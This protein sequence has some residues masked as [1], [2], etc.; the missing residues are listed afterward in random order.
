[1]P[2][3]VIGDCGNMRLLRQRS[4]YFVRD[5]KDDT[6]Q[7]IN[8]IE[9]AK[10]LS[11]GVELIDDHEAPHKIENFIN[12]WDTSKGLFKIVGNK[13]Q[14]DFRFGIISE[15][16][17]CKLREID[18]IFE[19]FDLFNEFMFKDGSLYYAYAVRIDCTYDGY[20]VPNVSDIRINS[21]RLRDDENDR[22]HYSFCIPSHFA[23]YLMS[24]RGLKDRQAALNVFSSGVVDSVV[25]QHLEG[26]SNGI[27]KF[28][29]W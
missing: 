25:G 6:I 8:G 22:E 23:D 21:A 20:S 16:Y 9:R 18:Y 17:Q 19:A 12:A 2:Y 4:L 13:V 29:K 27:V 7:C 26:W 5:S 24:I 10:L 28:Y 11:N 15:D 14:L 1:M 3:I